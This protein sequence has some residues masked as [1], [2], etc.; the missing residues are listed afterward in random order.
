MHFFLLL[1]RGWFIVKSLAK[2][3]YNKLRTVLPDYVRHMLANPQSLLTR[4]CGVHSL[5][6]PGSILGTENCHFVVMLN[7]F[8]PQVHVSS[9]SC[10]HPPVTVS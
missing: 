7:A 4:F 10:Y 3:D 2:K 6:L 5:S 1:F 9:H 8:P